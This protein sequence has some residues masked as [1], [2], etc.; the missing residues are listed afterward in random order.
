MSEKVI[1]DLGPIFNKVFNKEID[2]SVDMTANDID[3]WNS[4]N[5]LELV[6]EIEAFFNIKFSINELL[7]MNDVGDLVSTVEK[8]LGQ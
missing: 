3:N 5:N 1:K 4:M 8:H 7:I 6:T 2:L